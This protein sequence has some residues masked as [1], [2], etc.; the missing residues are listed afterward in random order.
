MPARA[1]VARPVIGVFRHIHSAVA[2]WRRGATAPIPSTPPAT[3]AEGG[4]EGCE[5]RLHEAAV[6]GRLCSAMSAAEA[7]CVKRM[8][9]PVVDAGLG[10]SGEWSLSA[11]GPS[12][13]DMALAATDAAIDSGTR[14]RRTTARCAPRASNMS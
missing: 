14:A 7:I 3:E 13:A 12:G 2:Q 4:E 6:E 1:V 10:P 5:L 9:F 8:I 11:V